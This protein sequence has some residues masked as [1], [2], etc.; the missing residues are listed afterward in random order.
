MSSPRLCLGFAFTIWLCL[1]AAAQVP[2]NELD[3]H[4]PASRISSAGVPVDMKS[5]HFFHSVLENDRVRIFKVEI[6]P[7]QSS[8]LDQHKHDYIVVSLGKNDFEIAGGGMTFPMQMDD[9]EIQVLKSGAPHRIT[10]RSSQLLRLLELEVL[11]EVHPDQPVCG[12]GGRRCT[13][14]KFG[15]S[16]IGTYTRST[17]FETDTVKLARIELGPESLLP[18]HRHDR[19]HVLLAL[20]DVSLRDETGVDQEHEIHL[21]AG[22]AE[23][24]SQAL[25]HT[26]K[27]LDKQ[28]VQFITVEFK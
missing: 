25:V 26:L 17:L 10:N 7:S 6:P 11:R 1:A 14:G 22:Q 16:D 20:A 2:R 9:G 3:V 8:A 27:N 4:R 28:D 24:Y 21:K 23:W 19:C 12:L 15:H 13:D 18:E 5:D